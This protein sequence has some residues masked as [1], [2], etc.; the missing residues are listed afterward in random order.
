[1]VMTMDNDDYSVDKP[2]ETGQIASAS[3]VWLWDIQTLPDGPSQSLFDHQAWQQTGRILRSSAGRGQ[4]YFLQADG[5]EIWVG[6]H[7]QRGGL[8][9][10]INHDRYLW[11]GAEPSRPAGE[12]NMLAQLYNQGLPVPRPIAAR[13]VRRGPW[14][15]ADLLTRAIPDTQPLADYLS[16]SGLADQHWYQ[17]GQTVARLHA[18]GIW[19]ADLNARNILVSSDRRFY[20]LDFDRA[21]RRRPG[22][23]QTANLR[24]LQ[25]SLHKFAQRWSGLHFQEADWQHLVAGYRRFF[26]AER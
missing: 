15:R 14:Y 2:V 18:C 19:H 5:E 26:D 13:A 8:L 22:R 24:R 21:R 25:R 7:Y 3:G 12:F 23:W 4:A 11:T 6:R 20:L 1:M 16:Q 17:L 10:W 9:A